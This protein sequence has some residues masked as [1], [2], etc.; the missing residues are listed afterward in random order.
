MEDVKEL[1]NKCEKQRSMFLNEI[2]SKELL[3]EELTRRI[4]RLQN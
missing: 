2:C 1:E 3:I 4:G